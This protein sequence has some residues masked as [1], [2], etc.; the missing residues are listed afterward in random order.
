MIRDET[1]KTV[2]VIITVEEG[3][4]FFISSLQVVGLDRGDCKTPFEE[5]FGRGMIYNEH[6]AELF[7]KHFA[8]ASLADIPPTSRI[9]LVLHNDNTVDVVFDFREPEKKR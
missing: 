4:Q 3:K 2:S 7:F 8:P 5:S 6:L 9:Q 1:H